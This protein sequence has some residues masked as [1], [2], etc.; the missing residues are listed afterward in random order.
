M[1]LHDAASAGNTAAIEL[2][3]KRGASVNRADVRY[4]LRLLGALRL[5]CA[6]T[7]CCP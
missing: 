6:A 2:L 7:V 3:L 5:G 4:D 1:P